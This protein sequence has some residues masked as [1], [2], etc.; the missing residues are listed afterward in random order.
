[1]NKVHSLHRIAFGYRP[2]SQPAFPLA[3]AWDDLSPIAAAVPF[4]QSISQKE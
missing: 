2:E 1:M 3:A 4:G